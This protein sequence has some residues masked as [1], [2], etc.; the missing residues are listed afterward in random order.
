[1]NNKKWITSARF[2]GLAMVIILSVLLGSLMG[3]GKDKQGAPPPPTETVAEA[4][5]QTV[6]LF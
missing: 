4:K 3:C 6:P 2:N 5:T 1:M